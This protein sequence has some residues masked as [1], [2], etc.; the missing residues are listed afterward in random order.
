MS[1]APGPVTHGVDSPLGRWTYTTWRPAHLHG[2]V[3]ELG[4][5]EGRLGQTRERAFP[6][7]AMD[8]IVQLENRYRPGAGP[9]RNPYSICCF[10]GVMEGAHV[11]EADPGPT[12]VLFVKLR[13]AAF[14]P[15]FGGS[16]P[17]VTGRTVDV[18]DLAGDAQELAGRCHDAG[19]PVETLRA[20]SVWVER[21]LRRGHAADPATAWLAE[22]IRCGRGAVSI[23]RLQELAGGSAARLTRRFREQVGVSPKRYARIHRFRHLLEGLHRTDT[24]L[25]RL[26]L[27]AGYYD[28][29]HMTTEFRA[30][31]GMSPGEYRRA[32][33]YPGSASLAE[34]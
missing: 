34:S 15:L 8:L 20:A 1:G 9:E 29:S 16:A 23:A 26:A 13:P 31:A 2:Y 30:L 21:R 10:N 3:S 33:R 19:T 25:A 6:D 24:P 27:D 22:R 5:F 12:R 7:G 18:A 11:V 14:L 4:L 32:T 17:D 28:Q